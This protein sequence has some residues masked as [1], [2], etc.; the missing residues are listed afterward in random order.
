MRRQ[1]RALFV[2]IAAVSMLV[3][4]SPAQAREKSVVRPG[5]SIQAAVDAADPGDT[6]RVRRGTY[7]ESVVVSTDELTLRGDH[8]VLEPPGP[9]QPDAC[10]DFGSGICVLGEVDSA[11]EKVLAN[12]TIK[13]VVSRLKPCVSTG[14]CTGV[15]KRRNGAKAPVAAARN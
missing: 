13:D 2:T 11:V 5:E 9:S 6:I 12:I 3:A 1:M 4:V 8:A 14:V 7:R 10:A 15:V